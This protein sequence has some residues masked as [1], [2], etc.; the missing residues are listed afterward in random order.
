M[1]YIYVV[2]LVVLLTPTFVSAQVF[3]DQ[4]KDIPYTSPSSRT[5]C[6]AITDVRDL[7][8]VFGV[9]FAAIMIIYGGIVYLTAGDDEEKTKKA[10][11]II[12][13]GIIGLVIILVAAFLIGLV[14]EFISNKFGNPGDIPPLEP[15]YPY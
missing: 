15:N 7:L 13:N 6:N 4:C 9:A 5:L 8:Y 12:I 3:G 2:L 1:K 14:S 10:K 11:K